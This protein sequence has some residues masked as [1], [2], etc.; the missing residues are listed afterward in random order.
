M[1]RWDWLS[2]MAL[3][4]GW[5]RGVEVGVKEGQTTF[6]LLDKVGG[7]TMIAVDCWEP[8]PSEGQLGYTGWPHDKHEAVFRSR[9]A[10]YPGRVTIIKGRSVIAADLV[11]HESVD[12]VFIDACHSFSQVCSDIAAWQSK[13]RPGGILCGHD[14]NHPGVRQ[15][16]NSSLVRIDSAPDRCWA[17]EAPDA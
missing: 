1:R 13:V 10:S 16:V 5:T 3:E 6:H 11:D 8:L 17:W 14:Y 4:K 12:F 7:L 15:A 2:E 9:A